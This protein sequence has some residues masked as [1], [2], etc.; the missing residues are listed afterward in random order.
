VKTSSLGRI[1]DAIAA[2]LDICKIRTYDGEPA[3]K[4]ETYLMM[5]DKSIIK[6]LSAFDQLFS[7]KIRGDKDKA[8]IAYSL[9][10]DI[11]K[12]FVDIAYSQGKVIDVSGGISY[13]EPI[14]KILKQLTGEEII[15][16]KKITPGDNGISYGQNI[17]ASLYE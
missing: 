12:V 5:G 13:D 8:D 9:V 7:M 11:L 1:L 16:H 15:M 6:I 17:V 2:Y 10:Y 3:M 4:L 14:V